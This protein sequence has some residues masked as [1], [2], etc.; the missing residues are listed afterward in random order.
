[1]A[2]KFLVEDNESIPAILYQ[3]NTQTGFTD[4]TNDILALNVNGEEY[5]GYKRTRNLI[6][7]QVTLDLNPSYPTLDYSGWASYPT[8]KKDI[9][10][11][12]CVVPY[13]LRVPHI[14]EEEDINNWDYL[15]TECKKDRIEIIE[16]IRHKVAHEVRKEVINYE[17]SN[18]FQ[19]ST[20]LEVNNYIE[21]NSTLFEDWLN[22]KVGTAYENDGF[23]QKTY[24]STALRDD[25]LDIYNGEY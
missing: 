19:A 23:V 20:D 6:K 4:K 17:Q 16:E 5:I 10:V 18:D 22:N 25:I 11:K 8:A 7:T 15:V 1:M 3:E 24:F 14:T 2:W 13:S 12:W 21:S 9:A